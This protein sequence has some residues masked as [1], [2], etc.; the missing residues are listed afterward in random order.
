MY[1]FKNS[2]LTAK[3][4]HERNCKIIHP[5][6]TSP[7]QHYQVNYLQ[8]ATVPQSPIKTP[9]FLYQALG[10]HHAI[11]TTR[12]L[13]LFAPSSA[14]LP[15]KSWDARPE[16]LSPPCRKLVQANPTLPKNSLCGPCQ[17]WCILLPSRM[18]AGWGFQPGV[19]AQH[20]PAAPFLTCFDQSH[21][22]FPRIRLPGTSRLWFLLWEGHTGSRLDLG[23]PSLPVPPKVSV[24]G[25]AAHFQGARTTFPRLLGYFFF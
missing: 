7:H 20:L 10:P 9:G 2:K 15:T 12:Y 19:P 5:L 23:E 22:H 13:L 11:T 1:Y 6:Y 25:L 3:K 4:I 16:P 21:A 8:R 14:S 24:H 17:Y 18:Q